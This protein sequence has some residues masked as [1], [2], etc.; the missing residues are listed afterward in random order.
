MFLIVDAASELPVAIT[1]ETRKRNDT[2]ALEPLTDT[3]GCEY[4]K[5]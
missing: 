3:A 2:V 5:I 1:M 4:V